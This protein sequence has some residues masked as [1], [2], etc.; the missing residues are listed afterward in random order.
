MAPNASSVKQV[1]PYD[2]LK[3]LFSDLQFMEL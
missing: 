2:E 1:T 3:M